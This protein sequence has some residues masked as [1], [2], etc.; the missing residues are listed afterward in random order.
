MAL[1]DSEVEC[2]PLILVAVL[3]ILNWEALAEVTAA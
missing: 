2:E 3:W 1:L